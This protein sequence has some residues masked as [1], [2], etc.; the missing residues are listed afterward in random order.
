MKEKVLTVGINVY[1]VEKY[2]EDCLNSFVSKE[3][4]NQLEVLVIIDGSP[5]NSL[6]IAKEY[7]RKYPNI[8]RVINKE[9][10]GLGSAVNSAIKN[11]KGKYYKWLDGD[12][13]MSPSGLQGLVK[14]ASHSD[15]DLIVSPYITFDDASGETFEQMKVWWSDKVD[16]VSHSLDGLVNMENRI[17]MHALCTRID[18]LKKNGFRLP[19]RRYYVDIEY[20]VFCLKYAKTVLFLDKP[21]YLYRLGLDSQSVSINGYRKYFDDHEKVVM[22]VNEM[23]ESCLNENSGREERLSYSAVGLTRMMSILYLSC[24]TDFKHYL[25]WK[26]FLNIFSKYVGDFYSERGGKTA[27]LLKHFGY[28]GF[29]IVV[30]FN[31]RSLKKMYKTDP[32]NYLG[33]KIDEYRI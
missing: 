11:A 7:V 29:V 5:D 12:D 10:G 21:V 31:K 16:Y 13:M 20:V 1:G 14:A 28:L 3:W 22:S 27:F 2:L 18:L 15:A 9:N 8:F 26:S 4:N 23:Y 32:C 17:P 33:I 30:S 6:S 19:D 25:R 24:F